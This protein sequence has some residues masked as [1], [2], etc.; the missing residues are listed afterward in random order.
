MY[1]VYNLP[2]WLFELL[3]IIFFIG[4]SLVGLFA[5]RKPI[6]R[7]HTVRSYNDIV[8]FYLAAITV[9][10]G[11]TLGL[12]AIGAWTT[13]T[14]TEAKVSREA[15]ALSSLYRSVGSIQ[16]PGRS[17]L[18]NDLRDYARRVIEIGWPEQRRGIPPVENRVALD[19]FQRD[20]HSVD[21]VTGTQIALEQD[22]S[23][24]F[25][26]LEQ[27]RS[28]RLDSVSDELPTPLWTLILV[29]AF[30]CIVVTWFFQMESMKMH[31]WMT[32]LF[33]G[34][35]GLMVFMTAAL[36]NPYRGKISVSP[37]PLQRV[38]IQMLKPG[39]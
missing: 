17:L 8:G 28:I 21:F 31:I 29:G 26:T 23:R 33:A 24:D 27:A 1:W 19:K 10:Y 12:L 13:Y 25:D 15:A 37:E 20:F 32:V 36:D 2:N 3:T 35:I 14:E 5:T 6:R 18:Q 9:F 22:I 39:K 4:F 7:I 11:V 30:L 16:E 34:L 38:Y